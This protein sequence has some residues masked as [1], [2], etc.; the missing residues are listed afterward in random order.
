VFDHKTLVCCS[1]LA[2]QFDK[3]SQQYQPYQKT[4]ASWLV[5][6]QLKPSNAIKGTAFSSFS[7]EDDFALH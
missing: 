4:F 1:D 7:H 6:L 2:K 5:E 3:S